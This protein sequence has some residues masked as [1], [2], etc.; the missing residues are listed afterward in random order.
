MAKGKNSVALFEVIRAAQAKQQQQ[1]LKQQQ[2]AQKQQARAQEGPH[3]SASDLLW[4]PIYWFKGKLAAQQNRAETVHR[5]VEESTSANDLARELAKY[6]VVEAEEV[7][8]PSLSEPA[9]L[10]ELARPAETSF[11]DASVTSD[12]VGSY[13][14]PEPVR[15]EPVRI[16]NHPDLVQDN[17]SKSANSRT[18]LFSAPPY[19]SKIDPAQAPASSTTHAPHHDSDF[20]LSYV[21]LI[22]AGFAIVM[23]VG[24]AIMFGR[25]KDQTQANVVPKAPGV[26]D[27]SPA[28]KA[29]SQKT[30]TNV[31]Q[32]GIAGKNNKNNS[33][34][35]T[36]PNFASPGPDRA[37]P[38][39]APPATPID[40]PKNVTRTIGLQY[41]IMQSYPYEG[42]AKQAVKDLADNGIGATV[43]K[44]LP[45]SPKW[46]C[47][48]GIE[49][50][51]RLSENPKYDA[52]LA[53]ISA[54]NDKRTNVAK[55]QKFQPNPFRWGK[56][57]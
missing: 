45:W 15:P 56:A 42:D 29:P 22:A 57:K 18:P 13:T 39:L 40:P 54:V 27:V 10:A 5:T 14:A 24:L 3:R 51:D 48:V 26:L 16:L 49:G 43:E 2:Q 12:T 11:S 7:D 55:F 23:A 44:N 47:V 4:Q 8:E 53:S 25:Q 17:S 28:P 36:D 35:G 19:P 50:F 52:Y 37:L 21:A 46:Y 9:P 41:V 31:P 33:A 34:A 1:L 30:P 38:R 6:D 20:R 32:N